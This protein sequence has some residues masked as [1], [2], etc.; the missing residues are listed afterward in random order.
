MHKCPFCSYENENLDSIRIHGTKKHKK[1]AMEL[2]LLMFHDNVRPKCK[3]GCNKETKFANIHVGF[4]EYIR[5]HHSRVKNN[6][7]HN[8]KA[9]EKS[10][11]KRRE[12]I[13]DGTWVPW[14]KGETKETNHNVAN[15]AKKQSDNLMASHE[16]REARSE[17]LSKHRLDGTVPSLLGSDHPNWRGGVSSVQALSRSYVYSV[18]TY[19]KLHA[20]KFTCQ[21]CSSHENLCV[22]HDVERFAEILQKAREVLGDVTEDFSSHQAYAQWIADYH[23]KNDV[24]GIVL[25]E[26]CH[27]KE[28]LTLKS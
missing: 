26:K 17:R 8:T 10:Q 24:S 15:I 25:C 6:W 14:N 4:N 12:Q 5:G 20:S 28:H 16:R 18:W 13:A 27:S 22:H 19:P 1:S 9:L 21:R 11:D 2:R 7:G 3:C 23:V